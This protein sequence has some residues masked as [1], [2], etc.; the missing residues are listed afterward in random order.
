MAFRNT[1]YEYLVTL[2]GAILQEVKV[3]RESSRGGCPCGHRRYTNDKHVEQYCG[4]RSRPL[5]I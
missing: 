4:A 3:P 1:E 2:A 5:L